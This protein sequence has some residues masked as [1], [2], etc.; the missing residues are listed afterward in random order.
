MHFTGH[1]LS[2]IGQVLGHYRIV[3][4]IGAG[5]MGVVY[6]ATDTKLGRQ[7][8][9][10]VLP[11]TYVQDPDRRAR[12]ECEACSTATAGTTGTAMDSGI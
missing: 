2:M 11:E 9:I 7:V 3:N 6:R 4:E 10:K 5:G 12:F 1:C 8:A